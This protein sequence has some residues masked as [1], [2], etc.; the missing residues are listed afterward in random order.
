MAFFSFALVPPG[1]AGGLLHDG[2]EGDLLGRE[3]RLEILT[4]LTSLLVRLRLSTL[5][6]ADIGKSNPLLLLGEG[7]IDAV[8]KLL[9]GDADLVLL[10]NDGVPQLVVHVLAGSPVH[11]GH[12]GI[13]DGALHA[14]LL[15]RPKSQM[16]KSC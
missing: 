7:A 10:D 12:L 4:T 1:T 14:L 6:E 13:L 16:F 11:S 3:L 8:D 2:G 15:L 9:L 5:R